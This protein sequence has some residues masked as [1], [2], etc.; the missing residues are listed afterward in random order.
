MKRIV[1]LLLLA[2]LGL[3]GCASAPGTRLPGPLPEDP[4]QT[5]DLAPPEPLATPTPQ[6]PDRLL[7]EGATFTLADVVDVALRNNPATRSSWLRARA[8]AA[9]L[10]IARADYY[11]KLD[12]DVAAGRSDLTVSRGDP[13]VDSYGPTVSL[14][15]LLLDLGGRSAGAEEARLGLLA[16]D[17]AHDATVQDVVLGVTRS[18]VEY[19]SARAQAEAA[20]ASVRAAR[21]A[22]EAAT[23]RHDAGV[24]T[25][26]D[27]LQAR[28]ALS[29]AELQQLLYDG[30]TLAL[31]GALATAMGLPASTPY[32]VGPL[33]ADP[34]LET[35]END[36][37]ALI[38]QALRQR[39]DLAAAR[40]SANRAA[41]RVKSV[42]SDGLPRLSLAATAGHSWVDAG[43]LADD[44]VWSGRLLLNV[45]L[46]T[47]FE[48]TYLLR[49]AEDNAALAAAQAQG[50]E[51]Q[52]ILE[53]WVSSYGLRTATQLVRTSRDLLASASQSEAVALGRY[54]EG[55][56]TIIDVLA[57]QS[58]L[59]A[60]RAQEV[61]ARAGWFLAL[62]QLARD[63]GAAAPDFQTA[64]TSVK[65]TEP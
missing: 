30:Q 12:L 46:F 41:M 17:W 34:P 28:T 55:V 15:W 14:E 57:A 16:A 51:Q 60:A 23:V 45:P 8:A 53:V 9:Q 13:R 2:A 32:D 54:K 21:T 27:V 48:D 63:T 35:V 11:P 40:L 33:P 52:A 38:A 4:S 59:A 65:R 7:A 29:Q 36:V 64:V 39:P 62:A 18:L 42:R 22:L 56:G 58:A 61:Q 5:L 31:R 26:A 20:A 19:M 43:S 6:V 37:E 44:D 25:I 47:G 50:L 1:P 10:G 3:T 49:Q 24:G